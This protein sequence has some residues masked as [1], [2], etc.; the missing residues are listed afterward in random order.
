MEAIELVAQAFRLLQGEECAEDELFAKGQRTLAASLMVGMVSNCI[1]LEKVVSTEE[2]L[3][4][5]K[6]SLTASCTNPLGDTEFMTLHD[7][8]TNSE[9]H[10][11]TNTRPTNGSSGAQYTTEFPGERICEE[12]AHRRTSGIAEEG[13]NHLVPTL[14]AGMNERRQ[15]TL[16][17]AGTLERRVQRGSNPREAERMSE[18]GNCTVLLP[19]SI[20]TREISVHGNAKIVW[21]VPLK[22]ALACTQALL[23]GGGFSRHSGNGTLNSGYR[24]IRNTDTQNCHGTS[25]VYSSPHA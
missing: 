24:N 2:S 23:E 18:I 16:P 6:L 10:T 25:I 7:S 15:E 5:I 13:R 11:Q 22:I 1:A 19:S 21:R 4:D 9:R 3:G 12:V 8:G 14:P 20:V 17:E